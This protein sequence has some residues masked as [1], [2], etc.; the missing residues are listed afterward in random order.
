MHGLAMLSWDC[1]HICIFNLSINFD[2]LS[3]KKKQKKK[4]IRASLGA[5]KISKARRANLLVWI[6][7]SGTNVLFLFVGSSKLSTACNIV[8]HA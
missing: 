7:L 1:L 8:V 5:K 2:L 3:L 4:K 6:F